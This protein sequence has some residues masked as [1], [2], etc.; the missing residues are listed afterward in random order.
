M[1]SNVWSTRAAAPRATAPVAAALAGWLELLLLGA[2]ALAVRLAWLGADLHIDELYHLLAARG[3]NEQGVP[4]IG[5]GVYDRALLFTAL[6][7]WSLET[8]G[9]SVLAAR[10]PS[11]LA[12]TALVLVL[13]LWTRRVAGP[14]AAWAAG[15]L[16]AFSPLAVELSQLARFYALH[17]LL[18]WLAAVCAWRASA[19]AVPTATRLALTALGL[20]CALLAG[21]LQLL[22]LIGFAGIGL[23]LA[24]LLAPRLWSW[25]CGQ[26]VQGALLGL[27][28]A[29]LGTG[30]LA[31][32]LQSGVAE[33]LLERYRWT[34]LWAQQY[35]NQVHFYHVRLGEQY[36]VLWP[37]TAFAG[38][39]ALAWRPRAAAFCATIFGTAL[40]TASF[41][42]MKDDRYL[43][44]AL[45]FLFALWGIGLAAT[46][47]QLAGAS[48]DLADRALAWAGPWLR[49][50]RMRFA[51]VGGA[52]AFML[53][54]SGAPAKLAFD[55]ARHRLPDGTGRVTSD[56]REAATALAPWLGRADVV[57]TSDEMAALHH[58]GR[59]D[60]LLSATRLSE[61][62]DG[63]Q[64]SRD[65][66]TG[67]VIISEAASFRAL[68]ACHA[69]GLV[70]L[71]RR[72][73]ASDWAV[74]EDTLQTIGATVTRL[75]FSR[76]AELSIFWWQA[77]QPVRAD[78]PLP[79]E[80]GPH[81]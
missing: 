51:I 81:G 33:Q 3:W 24:G 65:P 21:H 50:P 49:T 38:L 79:L 17:A 37:L 70:I 15:L 78:C 52:V 1:S 28:L 77:R 56:W 30:S 72:D 35:H 69:S 16:L 34:P 26:G 59:A 12:G 10:L 20:L 8:L 25:L 66:R 73:L 74:G 63:R 57:I 48:L 14:V 29:L 75:E 22:T 31:V 44:F 68:L 7:G 60:V 39:A 5:T 6:V 32:L 55:L 4:A 62:G 2:L 18:F 64:F 45:P 76:L 42:G 61:V 53:S 67:V 19:V 40:L 27:G 71:S 9:G 47:R 23:W 43:F 54:A 58:L 11:V 36:P 41:A 13:F 80:V 46:W